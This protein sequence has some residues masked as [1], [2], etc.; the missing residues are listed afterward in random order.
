M[1]ST[2]TSNAAP[3]PP[4]AF[5]KF[6]NSARMRVDRYG[7]SHSKDNRVFFIGHDD[8]LSTI[9]ECGNPDDARAEL[10]LIAQQ[11]DAWETANN[12]YQVY[13]RQN[14]RSR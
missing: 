3:N 9:I 8:E 5:L 12:A 6:S 11:V 2:T 1:T 4:A 10:A 7:S 13:L 14:T